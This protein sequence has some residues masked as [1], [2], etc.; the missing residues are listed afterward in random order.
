MK[1]LLNNLTEEEKNSIRQQHT[2][3]MKVSNEKFSQLV[4]SKLGVVKP[5]LNEQTE[6]PSMDTLVGSTI[7]LY[8]SRSQDRLVVGEATIKSVT[9][10]SDT[11]FTME[12]DVKY[13]P[14]LMPG[15]PGP[16]TLTLK[17][18]CNQ[19]GFELISKDKPRTLFNVDFENYC[20]MFCPNPKKRTKGSSF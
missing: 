8:N 1:H 11:Q 9:K 14:T 2:G 18:D 4:E 12:V 6:T 10:D 17:F 7:R 16:I 19:K 5:I 13:R 20:E 15:N 3:G